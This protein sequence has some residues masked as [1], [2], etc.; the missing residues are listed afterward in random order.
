MEYGMYY[1]RSTQNASS[2]V[3]KID[4]FFY[5]IFNYLIRRIDSLSVYMLFVG[6]VSSA[7]FTYYFPQIRL[8]A[9]L[10]VAL[11]MIVTFV[12]FLKGK[13]LDLIFQSVLL[14]FVLFQFFLDQARD[15]H[16]NLAPF[17][18]IIIALS[19][20]RNN[21]V[22]NNVLKVV[23]VIN[24]LVMTYEF[25]AS[26][27]LIKVVE[28]N[29][30]EPG[31]LQGLFSYSKEC[32]FFLF[33]SF[34]FIRKY[35]AS[36]FIK[37]I[38]FASSLMSGSR[39]VILFVL[40]VISMDLILSIRV[41]IKVFLNILMAFLF[42]SIVFYFIMVEHFELGNFYIFD[43][44]VNSFNFNSSSH[45][46]RFFYWSSYFNEI[47][48]YS[49][50]QLFFGAGTYLNFL[51]GNGS[52]NTYL[53]IVSQYG[54]IGLIIFCF[55]LILTLGLFFRYP[56]DLYPIVIMLLFLNVGRIGVG[57]S[58]GILMWCYVINTIYAKSNMNHK[59]FKVRVNI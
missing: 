40:F 42:G 26:D 19:F 33:M 13:K 27:Y 8:L 35:K 55:P 6:F 18:A 16:S 3:G 50:M 32:G 14:V 15:Y 20:Y 4:Q 10:F 11:F 23:V 17:I 22:I 59:T 1:S 25:F 49:V 51:I 57:W 54:I 36:A 48:N 44:M 12:A 24:F 7:L 31:R 43:R 34:I 52:E 45:V 39:T 46:A 28:G 29:K 37:L 21:E 41:N 9:I 2:I 38:I 58:D 30:Y 56:Y 5:V 53:M 47:G